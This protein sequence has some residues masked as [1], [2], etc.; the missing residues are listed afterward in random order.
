MIKN[1]RIKVA[2]LQAQNRR[3]PSTTEKDMANKGEN[4][5]KDRVKPYLHWHEDVE[6]RG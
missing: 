3:K 6:S 1:R 2:A 4:T 5:L